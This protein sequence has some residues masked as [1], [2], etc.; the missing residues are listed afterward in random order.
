LVISNT[1]QR[2]QNQRGIVLFVNNIDLVKVT[3]SFLPKI[4]DGTDP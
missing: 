4:V 2:K 3:E 1:V